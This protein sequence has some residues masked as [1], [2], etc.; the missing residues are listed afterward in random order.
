MIL[1]ERGI[2]SP[3]GKEKWTRAAI[4]KLLSSRKYVCHLI[5]MEDFVTVQINKADRCRH[6]RQI[7]IN[8][9]IK[10]KFVNDMLNHHRKNSSQSVNDC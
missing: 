1:S 7:E 6:I 5:S 10:C 4:E 8:E 9:D 3:S 2:P